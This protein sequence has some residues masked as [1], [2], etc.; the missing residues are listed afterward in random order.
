MLNASLFDCGAY[1]KA[2]TEAAK[3]DFSKPNTRRVRKNL[4]HSTVIHS[5]LKHSFEM[6]Q[7]FLLAT[8][9]SAMQ[10]AAL[11]LDM[12]LVDSLH[13]HRLWLKH[14]PQALTEAASRD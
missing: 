13:Q 6:P 1:M 12:D 7:R 2:L 10:E 8:P 4:L 9:A 11:V 3:R 5:D 14:A